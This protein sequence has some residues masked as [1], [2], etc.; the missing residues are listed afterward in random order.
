M[1]YTKYKI[2]IELLKIFSLQKGNRLNR[3]NILGRGLPDSPGSLEYQMK[4]SFSDEERALAGEALNELQSRR[5]VAP[6]YKDLISPGDWL[7]I[8][9]LGEQALMTGALDELDKLL[10]GLESEYNLVSMHHGAYE[11]MIS[12]HIDWPRHVASSCR[13]LVIKVLHTIASDKEVIK[14]PRFVPDKSSK[15]NITRKE[16][17]RFYLRNKPNISKRNVEVIEKACNLIEACYKKLSAV[18]HTDIKE[19]E[20]LVKLTE[21]ALFF[22]LS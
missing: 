21:D 1:R 6:T 20:Y 22:L 8:T 16:R 10:L 12:K 15:N 13:E 3:Y 19:V 11:A 18:S 2:K 17:I 14:D 5:L 9:L 7:K 4:T